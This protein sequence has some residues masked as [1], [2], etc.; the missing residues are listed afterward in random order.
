MMD[1]VGGYS[2]AVLAICRMA[3]VPFVVRLRGDYWHEMREADELEPSIWKKI[4]VRRQ[5]AFVRYVI[6]RADLVIPVS[7]FL[8]RRIL[9]EINTCDPARILPAPAFV[10]LEHL[11]SG[12]S[13]M[14]ARQRLQIPADALAVCTVT[15]F[16]YLAKARGLLDILAVL[17][18]L[19]QEHPHLHWL[20]AGG[21]PFQSQLEQ[22]LVAQAR[23]RDRMHF[24]GYCSD[25]R[26][27]YMASDVLIHFTS[28]DSFGS[29]VIE[30]QACER[31]VVVNGY[32]GI[33]EQVVNGETGYVV[34]PTESLVMQGLLER[35]LSDPEQRARMGRAG[36]QFVA[37]RYGHRAVGKRFEQALRTLAGA[38][39]GPDRVTSSV[40]YE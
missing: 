6:R 8:K 7:L 30:A 21:G 25:I 14:E 27:V 5:L 32:G 2:L 16:S 36:R 12:E 35:L 23:S 3:G 34:D 9:E 26:G 15:N 40:P 1:F 24:L 33:P 28:M 37:S 11:A 10:D 31:P 17:D 39:S 22:T 19:M 13:R 29:I 4:A 18:P 20:I 38:D